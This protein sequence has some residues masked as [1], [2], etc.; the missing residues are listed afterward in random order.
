MGRFV[1]SAEAQRVRNTSSSYAG[2]TSSKTCSGAGTGEGKNLGLL[3]SRHERRGASAPALSR[4]T[5][6]S[7]PNKSADEQEWVDL[8]VPT[9]RE[10]GL[11]EYEIWQ[12]S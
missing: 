6:Q 4:D 9:H 2:T 11:P 1:S 7:V 12:K 5:R 3:P 10:T 8:Y